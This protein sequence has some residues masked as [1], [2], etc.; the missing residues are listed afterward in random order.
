VNGEFKRM[1]KDAIVAWF[2][3][4]LHLPGGTLGIHEHLSQDIRM[5]S[6]ESGV[7]VNESGVLPIRP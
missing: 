7:P 2:V 3:I 1:Y 5:E 4:S 6:L